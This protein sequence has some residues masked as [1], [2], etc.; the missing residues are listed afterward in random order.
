[1]ITDLMDREGAGEYDLLLE[2]MKKTLV[3]KMNAQNKARMQKINL[4]KEKEK[5]KNR[6]RD[7]Y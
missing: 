2:E 4:A 6:H 7:W 3:S 5:R 1:M